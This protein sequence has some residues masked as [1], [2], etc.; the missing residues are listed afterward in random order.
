MYCFRQMMTILRNL[1]QEVPQSNEASVLIMF[2]Q[3]VMVKKITFP[4][5]FYAL[6]RN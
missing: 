4:G 2:T 3:R 6:K 5:Q 1:S